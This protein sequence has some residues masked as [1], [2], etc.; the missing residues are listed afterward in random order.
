MPAAS[1]PAPSGP[2]PGASWISRPTPWPSPW[3][4]C[5]AC[6]AAAITSRE[7]ES[8]ATTAAPAARA[9]PPAARAAA[10]PPPAR[11]RRPGRR[12]G[13]PGGRGG[14]PQLV[15]LA[16]PVGDVAEHQRAGH[17]GVVAV[18]GRAE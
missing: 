12:G 5:S 4:K 6:P 8:T 2:M 10:P 18:D 17:G 15:D 9:A 14:R 3:E 7:A 13:P 11:G 16:L 1:L